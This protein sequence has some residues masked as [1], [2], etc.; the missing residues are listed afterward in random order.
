MVL[1]APL[2]ILGARHMYCNDL[3]IILTSRYLKFSSPCLFK[4]IHENCQKY[5][6]T[7]SKAHTHPCSCREPIHIFLNAIRI[8]MIVFEITII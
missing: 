7:N 5:Y 8:S 2:S 4:T 6:N 1:V 3:P